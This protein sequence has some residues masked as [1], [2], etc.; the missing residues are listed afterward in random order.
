MFDHSGVTGN[1]SSCHN[2]TTATGKNNTH[3]Q[4]TNACE[5]CH[6]TNLFNPATRVDHAEVLGTC[7]SCHNGTTAPGKTANH[8]A[9]NNTCDDCH[10]TTTF[11][12][13]VFDHSGVTGNCSSL[14]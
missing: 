8:I 2:G 12:Q 1:C 3:M 9:S 4:T 11:T 13:A 6:G 14:P 5:A 7:F 10:N